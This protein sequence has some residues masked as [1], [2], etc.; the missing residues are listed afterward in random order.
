MKPPTYP[1]E[2]Q[3]FSL[4]GPKITREKL[5]EAPASAPIRNS[6][7]RTAFTDPYR[8]PELQYSTRPGAMDAYKIPSRYHPNPPALKKG[9]Q[10]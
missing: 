8:A 4:A 10:E 6:T 7:V 1:T 5:T 9:S 3:A 2:A